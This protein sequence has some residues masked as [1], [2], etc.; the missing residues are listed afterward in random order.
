MDNTSFLNPYGF[1]CAAL[2]CLVLEIFI[3]K[4]FLLYWSASFALSGLIKFIFLDISFYTQLI[5]LI[6]AGLLATFLRIHALKHPAPTHDYR[7]KE[8][9]GQSFPLASTLKKNK[10]K[11]KV[12]GI[13]WYV[14]SSK[15]L[16]KGTLVTVIKNHGTVLEVV[17]H[18]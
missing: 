14:Q 7:G 5:V 10:A 8:L 2:I 4:K 9:I 12:R 16:K 17:A 11:I 13:T 18:D 15:P 3:P 1:Y 6:I